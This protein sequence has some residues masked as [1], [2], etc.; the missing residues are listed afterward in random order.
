MHRASGRSRAGRRGRAVIIVVVVV[1]LLAAGGAAAWWFL[2]R[3]TPEKTV[4]AYVAAAKAGDQE[5]V[6]S[7]LS[8]ETVTILEDLEKQ[9]GQAFG[10]PGSPAGPAGMP[11]GGPDIEMQVGKASVEGDTATVPVEVKM[12]EA[13]ML[14]GLPDSMK[15]SLNLVREGGQWKIDLSDQLKMAQQF[16]KA[17][18]GSPEEMQKRVAELQEAVK[19]FSE[20]VADAG[21]AGATKPPAGDAAALV[22]EGLAAKKAGQL[23]KAASSL[24]AAIAQEPDN[25]EAHWGLAWV[26]ADQK[27]NGEAVSH[28]RKVVELADDAQKK[29]DA[30]AAIDRLQ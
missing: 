24:Q 12:G 22:K 20:G 25:V 3:P 8:S 6:K 9:F 11:P 13:P 29:T 27:R 19:K 23:D 30:E 15:M 21:P 28:F 10:K 14:P 4:E 18:D 16:A 1:L 5:K 17:F 26:L 2:L 7:L